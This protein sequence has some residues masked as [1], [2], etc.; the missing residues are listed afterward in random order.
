FFGLSRLYHSYM[1]DTQPLDRCDPFRLAHALVH[2][3]KMAEA[4]PDAALA[5]V[6]LSSARWSALQQLAEAGGALSLSQLAGRLACVRSNVTQLVD[7][8]DA[9]QLVRR[10]HDRK[11]RRARSGPRSPLW[12]GSATR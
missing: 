8:L 7:R 1:N 3:G 4:C 10:V 11:D 2:G 9:E 5:E 6:D 12:D